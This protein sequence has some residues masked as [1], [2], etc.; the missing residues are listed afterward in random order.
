MVSF[1]NELDLQGAEVLDLGCGQGRDALM[2]ARLGHKVTGVDIS[3]TGVSQMVEQAE[4]EGLEVKGVVSDIV[5]Y[6]PNTMYD[7]VLLDRVLH[8]LETDEVRGSLLSKVRRCTRVN[9]YIMIAD[10][11]S[12]MKFIRGFF[13][14]QAEWIPDLNRGNFFVY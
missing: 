8:M 7:V 10:T 1:F 12:N 6:S 2:I 4:V 11:P 9:G 3:K 13:E 14:D 5:T